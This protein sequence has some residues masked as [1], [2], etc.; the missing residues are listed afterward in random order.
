[1]ECVYCAVRTE[2][3]NVIQVKFS[4]Q[5]GFPSVSYHQCSILVFSYTLLLP[6]GQMAATWEPSKENAPSEIGEH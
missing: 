4:L 2:C 3:L 5:L 1:M 6:E